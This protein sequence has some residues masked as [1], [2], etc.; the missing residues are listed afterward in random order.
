MIS[1][2]RLIT[3]G[4]CSADRVCRKHTCTPRPLQPPS[5][6]THGMCQARALTKH[7]IP[8]HDKAVRP[9]TR[10]SDNAA[11]QPLSSTPAEHAVT[12]AAQPACKD[13]LSI[14]RSAQLLL[15]PLCS[16]PTNNLN[17]RATLPCHPDHNPPLELHL[18]TPS[19]RRRGLLQHL[20]Y[21][22]PRLCCQAAKITQHNTQPAVQQGAHPPTDAPHTHQLATYTDKQS[23]HRNIDQ[24]PRRQPQTSPE[25]PL[26]LLE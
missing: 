15:V 19:F 18:A 23:I 25:T 1:T 5:H 9:Q 26:P 3:A 7:P 11:L 13:A 6:R 17:H 20:R 10:K 12:T 22:K 24:Y 21:S 4:R 14:A 2:H 8:R 16:T